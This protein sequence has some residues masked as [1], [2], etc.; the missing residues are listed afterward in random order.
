MRNEVKSG[1]SVCCAWVS[2]DQPPV[3][4]T[5]SSRYFVVLT[6]GNMRFIAW[7]DED[8]NFETNG[9]D[10]RRYVLWNAW[11]YIELPKAPPQRELIELAH[12]RAREEHNAEGQH[13]E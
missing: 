8:G 6:T 4:N 9:S 13:H 3:Q 10:G 5:D 1:E 7:L 11:G 2:A 12:K